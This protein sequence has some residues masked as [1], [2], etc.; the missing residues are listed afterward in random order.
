MEN[1]F[2]N[3]LHKRIYGK[4]ISNYFHRKKIKFVV[5]FIHLSISFKEISIIR[6][7]NS[8]FACNI[9]SEN[10]DI[11]LTLPIFSRITS[12]SEKLLNSL[13]TLIKLNRKEYK[14]WLSTPKFSKIELDTYLNNLSYK[15]KRGIFR[16][17]NSYSV[18]YGFEC[19]D[20][21]LRYLFIRLIQELGPKIAKDITCFSN[22]VIASIN[23]EF[24]YESKPLFSSI[25]KHVIL[26]TLESD[27]YYTIDRK[28]INGMPKVLIIGSYFGYEMRGGLFTA[29]QLGIHR[30]AS[31]LSFFGIHI[32]VCDPRL[33]SG[34]DIKKIV[35]SNNYD[36]VGFN[37]LY[38][39][40][41][42]LKLI[43]EV[44][45]VSPQSL[46]LVGGQ[47]ASFNYKT[48]FD[49]APVDVIVSAYGEFPML[50][51]I[52]DYNKNLN[53][54]QFTNI[55]GLFIKLSFDN[56]INTKQIK[57]ITYNDL[58]VVSLSLDFSKIPY[59]KYWNEVAQ[60]YSSRHLKVMKANDSKRTIRLY[61]E[62]H[63]PMKCDFCSSTNF[64][65]VAIGGVQKVRFL[66]ANDIV[67]L[68]TRALKEHPTTQAFYFNDDEFL[69]NKKRIF[70]LCDI[71]KSNTQFKGLKFICMARVDNINEEILLNLKEA[72]FIIISFGIESFSSRVLNDMDKKLHSAHTKDMGQIAKEAVELTLKAGITPRINFILFYPTITE[73]DLKI[74]ID[75][76]TELIVKGAPPTYYTFVELFPGAR[77][78]EKNYKDGWLYE[79][80]LLPDGS[81][82]EIPTKVLPLDLRIRK[83]CQTALDIHDEEVLKIKYKYNWSLDGRT[84]TSI[85]TLIL[86]K[87]LY[88]LLSLNEKL[89]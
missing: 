27:K 49:N 29:P 76:A 21:M 11:Y 26:P 39:P 33:C 72:G 81:T 17:L 65:D 64:L 25:A 86:F 24:N 53:N 35:K 73:E 13:S 52:V 43:H 63:C 2:R 41:D 30:I 54:E 28:P 77:I 82:I 67:L 70:D 48:I 7:I 37:V 1:L 74:T 40:F 15:G 44:Y 89:E 61:T 22:E 85:D 4:S 68:I 75:C 62:T 3:N 56:L 69:L 87:S 71:L 16:I 34:D 57:Q 19:F 58:R 84:P 14:D 46:F 80:Q 31:F 18:C 51:M 78:M 23:N 5:S 36:F 38:P 88:E 20:S 8:N 42:S 6:L 79:N 60:V 83:I 47:G 9:L 10:F 12:H 50:D 66:D 55:P 59:N 45:K 32:D